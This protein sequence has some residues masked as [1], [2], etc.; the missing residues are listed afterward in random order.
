MIG[1]LMAFYPGFDFE[2]VYGEDNRV[3]CKSYCRAEGL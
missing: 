2:E 1:I 3:A